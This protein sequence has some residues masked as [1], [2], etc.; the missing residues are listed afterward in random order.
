M[1][2]QYMRG[3]DV[4]RKYKVGQTGAPLTGKQFVKKAQSLFK[5]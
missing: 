1:D 4:V 3:N 2:I 5:T